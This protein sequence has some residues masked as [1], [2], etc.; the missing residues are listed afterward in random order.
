M[1]IVICDDERK[2]MKHAQMCI[3]AQN[4]ILPADTQIEMYSPIELKEMVQDGN[5]MCDIAILDIE[6]QGV[7]FDGIELATKINENYPECKIIYLTHILE[8][9]PNVY[10]TD[11]CYFVMKNNMEV[12]LPLAVKK[13]VALIKS[14][15]SHVQIELVVNGSKQYI[16]QNDILYIEKLN[17]KTYIH[18]E[19]E[20]YETYTA[21]SSLLH[22]M[23]EEMVRCHSSFIVNLSYVSRLEREKIALSDGSEI[24]IGK[25]YRERVKAEY[26][27]YWTIRT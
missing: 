8:F 27:K 23:N 9:A 1:R 4:E 7:A 24:P 19:N 11:H 15:E 5:L 10:E 17:R 13:A 21:L 22:K 3:E 16:K 20:T 6:F 12:M 14:R 26:L 18:T 25:T 2:E